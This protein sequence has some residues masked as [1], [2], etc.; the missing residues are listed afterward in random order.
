[1][2]DVS[3]YHRTIIPKGISYYLRALAIDNISK[4]TF[5]FE[6]CPQINDKL[7]TL[8]RFFVNVGTLGQKRTLFNTIKPLNC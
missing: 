4:I 5:A 3:K 7:T 2:S 1:M 8:S 6:E